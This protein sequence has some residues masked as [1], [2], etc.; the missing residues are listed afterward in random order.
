MYHTLFLQP[1]EVTSVKF[2]KKVTQTMK[3]VDV[4]ELIIEGDSNP[5]HAVASA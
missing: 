2:F 1:C 4:W 3:T 5:L